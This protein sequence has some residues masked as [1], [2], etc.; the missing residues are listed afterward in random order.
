M[1]KQLNSET[2]ITTRCNKDCLRA[3]A[4]RV[5]PTDKL[6]FTLSSKA[7]K[8][9]IET[10]FVTGMKD[11]AT[12]TERFKWACQLP[13]SPEW[14]RAGS[15]TMRLLSGVGAT[16]V[17]AALVND[18]AYPDAD[19]DCC[20]AAAEGGHLE[21]LQFLRST[22]CEW[23]FRTCRE[24]AR[25]GHFDTLRWARA[26]GCDC[27]S[28]TSTAAAAA[29]HLELFQW[30]T[31]EGCP[32]D[33][34]TCIDAA[35][36]GHLDVLKW[37][38]ARG[39][40]MGSEVCEVAAKEG[41][42]S[43]LQWAVLDHGCEPDQYTINSAAKRGDL[44]M[45]QWLYHRGCPMT[46][47][48]CKDAA[49]G[50]HTAVLQWLREEAA[51]EW[52]EATCY[53][54]AK[55]GHLDTLRWARENGSACPWNERVCQEAAG[56][57]HLDVLRYAHENGCPWSKRAC[58][59]AVEEGQADALMYC[60]IN[61]CDWDSYECYVA[62]KNGGPFTAVLDWAKAQG[63]NMA[64]IEEVAASDLAS[65]RHPPRHTF[66]PLCV[67]DPANGLLYGTNGHTSLNRPDKPV[68]SLPG[69]G[70]C[71]KGH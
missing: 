39:A 35:E 58:Y 62:A 10:P 21:T 8:D 26:N 65:G 52:D 30:A 9:A 31:M 24:A 69:N 28:E 54:A 5:S 33:G 63:Y 25:G 66:C 14:L 18:P 22:G 13:E 41:H 40:R 59:S 16:Q 4:E 37:A 6:V 12:S 42:L 29:G 43:V 60:V 47:T 32:W 19:A 2:I 1:T 51:C 57:G 55:N 3:I 36:G 53:A 68:L 70:R 23:D 67:K 38:A 17:L 50:G 49:A 7:M 61:G 46:F 64:S 20:Y 44:P 27:N 34:Y 71:Q 15:K 45:L 48:T 11:V 56:S